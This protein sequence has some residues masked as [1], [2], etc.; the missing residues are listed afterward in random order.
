MKLEL[1]DSEILERVK[2]YGKCRRIVEA[3]LADPRIDAL[4]EQANKVAITRLGF[5]D[6]GQ[7][8][9]K[10]VLLNSLKIFELLTPYYTPSIIAEGI[11]D[12]E[13]VMIALCTGAFLHDIGVSVTRDHHELLGALLAKDIVV[14]LLSEV[15]ELR[16][17]YRILPIILEAIVCHMGTY[18][19]TSL[20]AKI[21]GVADGTDMTKGRARIPFHIGKE[22]IHKFSAL[23]IDEIQISRGIDKLVRITASMQD[24]AGIFQIEEILLRKIKGA[25]LEEAIEV[26]AIVKG[27]EI[28]YL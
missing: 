3:L 14:D 15:Y 23:A 5:N 27:R 7:V 2:S 6:H 13:D 8:H 1:L 25:G 4:L 28:R 11:G 22:D 12:V 18:K 21:V 20:E 9:A 17:A 16:K 24:T 26:F 19:S 10:I